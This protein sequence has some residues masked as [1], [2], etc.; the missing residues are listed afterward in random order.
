VHG[1]SVPNKKGVVAEMIASTSSA[2]PAISMRFIEL[3]KI[4]YELMKLVCIA[5]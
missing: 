4:F 1:S 5:W 2:F 3:A